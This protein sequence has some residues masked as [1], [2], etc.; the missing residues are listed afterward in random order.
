MANSWKVK[1]IEPNIHRI[2]VPLER[3]ASWEQWVLLTADRH[4]DNISSDRELQKRHLEE[5][6]K[7]NAIIIDLGD[8][9]CAM[10]GRY[11]PRRSLKEV[12][13][14]HNV[15][16]YLNALSDTAAKWFK[17]YAANFAVMGF[18]N[19]E[20]SVHKNCGYDLTQALVRDLKSYDSP[21]CKGGYAGWIK[22]SFQRQS[23]SKD[24]GR[25]KPVGHTIT[26]Y[27][28]HGY[29]GDSPV[30]RGVIQTA[31]MGLYLP[32]AQIVVTGH[33]HNEW[34]LP[35]TRIRINQY[36]RQYRD[37][38]VHLKLPSYKD[39][40]GTGEGGWHIERGGPP[41]PTGATWLRF[42]HVDRA[43]EP[44]GVRFEY[45]RAQ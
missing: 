39:D 2:E 6:K 40:Y 34:A 31:R 3:N 38:Q 10:Q 35:I 20:S 19:H 18:G 44:A 32:D 11:D 1:Q 42:Y 5:A 41:K 12:R 37:E 9:F 16:D 22:F 33:T 25:G 24:I 7:R 14:E 15:T 26:L 23:T 29:G 43:P 36:D 21:V 27:Y 13:P 30:T 28:H 45:I 17:P 8:F 4:W